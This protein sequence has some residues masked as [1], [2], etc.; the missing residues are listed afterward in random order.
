MTLLLFWLWRN[1][2][3][4]KE[5]I[6]DGRDC[7]VCLIVNTHTHTHGV[8]G[9]DG[10]WQADGK[11]HLVF[12][13]QIERGVTAFGVQR[14]GNEGCRGIRA[15]VYSQLWFLTIWPN[16]IITNLILCSQLMRGMPVRRCL[17][18]TLFL[19][20]QNLMTSSLDAGEWLFHA[21][22]DVSAVFL[23]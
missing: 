21:V 20:S 3:A 15:S 13:H 9:G 5:N 12:L 7:P 16:P 14:L 23:P 8:S 17:S 1:Q 22:E 18:E 6:G 19:S 10:G 4:V 2:T 11:I